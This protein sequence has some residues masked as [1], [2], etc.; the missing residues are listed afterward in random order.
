[1]NDS[2]HIIVC[3]SIEMACIWWGQ[4][5]GGVFSW[6]HVMGVLIRQVGCEVVAFDR[7]GWGL[8]SPP[9]KNDWKENHLPNPY[10]LKTQVD[11]L[12]SFCLEIGFPLVVLAGH[13]EGGLHLLDILLQLQ[14][15]G[16]VLIRVSL[17]REVFLAFAMI[18][19]RTSLGKKNLVRPLLRTEIT[20]VVNRRSWYDATKLTTEVLN[21]YKV[22]LCIEGLDEALHEIGRFSSETFFSTQ[23]AE[24]LLKSL[25]VLAILVIAGAEDA[26]VSLKSSQVMASKLLNS[27]LVAIYEC[28]HLPHEECLKALLVALLPFIS[29]CISLTTHHHRM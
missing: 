14:I 3:L 25:E 5:G 12:L 15:R 16:I 28:G 1:M 20:Q 8:T 24:I 26:L 4:F 17:S 18:L 27:R 11:L 2:L 23:K 10:K 29:R 19:L 7:P 21:L 13:D 22:P 6:R 9:R